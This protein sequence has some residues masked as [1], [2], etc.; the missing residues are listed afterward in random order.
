MTKIPTEI[1]E[2]SGGVVFNGSQ[3]L[4]VEVSSPY[5]GHIFPKG[6]MEQG[7]SAEKTAVR[8]V[9]EETGHFARIIAP[10]NDLKYE[11]M[12]KGTCIKKTVHY[13]VMTL[14]DATRISEQKPLD[15]EVLYPMWLTFSEALEMLT[16]DNSRALL[17]QAIELYT[18]YATKR[19]S[20]SSNVSSEIK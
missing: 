14:D 3:V 12:N 18:D 4:L 20:F 7:E 19:A 13:F 11:Y 10:L 9:L 16:Y 6:T 5:Q 8:E 17:L 15:S 2:S 1:H